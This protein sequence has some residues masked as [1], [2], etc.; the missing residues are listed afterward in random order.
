MEFLDVTKKSTTAARKRCRSG[1]QLW[2]LIS[3]EDDE[4]CIYNEESERRQ[5]YPIPASRI[6][7]TTSTLSPRTRISATR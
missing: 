1:S 2:S 7:K 5:N 3:T 6:P 4:E